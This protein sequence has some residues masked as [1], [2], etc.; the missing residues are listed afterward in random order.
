MSTRAALEAI[1][2]DLAADRVLGA[3]SRRLTMEA[4][5]S[6]MDT[7]SRAR[8]AFLRR[9]DI[10]ERDRLLAEL[11]RKYCGD[12]RGIRPKVRRILQWTLRYET[13]GWR[14]DRHATTCP[15]HRIGKPEGIIWAVL[16]TWPKMPGERQLHEILSNSEA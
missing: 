1:Y 11:A 7:P 16:K 5:R 4:L 12:L 6:F 9:K 13:S 15:A 10:T 14:H 2:A 3:K 8:D